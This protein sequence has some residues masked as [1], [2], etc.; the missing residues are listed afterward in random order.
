MVENKK[1]HTDRG[2]PSDDTACRD[3]LAGH[4]YVRRS[5]VIKVFSNQRPRQEKRE[6]WLLKDLDSYKTDPSTLV[7]ERCLF[8]HFV[9]KCHH[10][11]PTTRI[12]SSFVP[13]NRVLP[14]SI[15]KSGHQR[16]SRSSTPRLPQIMVPQICEAR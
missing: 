13:M 6:N 7:L 16:E 12:T 11:K 15:V 3:F 1:A 2:G 14:L 5:N 9:H 8:T 4:R 10:L